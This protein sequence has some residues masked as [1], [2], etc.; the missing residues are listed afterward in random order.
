MTMPT[1]ITM[2][3]TRVLSILLIPVSIALLAVTAVGAE[4]P[5]GIWADVQKI[6]A[7]TPVE[8]MQGDSIILRGRLVSAAEDGMT[9]RVGDVDHSFARAALR[10]VAVQY[11][12]TAKGTAIGLLAG[13]VLAYPNAKLQGGGAAAGTIVSFTAIGAGIGAL[14]K[15]YRTVYRVTQAG[16]PTR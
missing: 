11:R 15:S 1:N 3:M 2:R 6:Q 14:S 8:V 4:K 12:R 5:V 9:L 10:S 7:G 13:L 16:L